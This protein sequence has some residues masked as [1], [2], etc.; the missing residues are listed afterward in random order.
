MEILIHANGLDLTDDL[1]E[2]VKEK[3]GHI[4][5]YAPRAVRV[6]VHFDRVSAHAS[7]R[8]F[9][10]HILCELPGRDVSARVSAQN[11][12]AALDSVVRKIER[13]IRRRKTHWLARRHRGGTLPE[14]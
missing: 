1:R 5:L 10:V 3:I 8:Q 4:E 6:R 7:S 13:Q 2:K 12:M 14:T 9:E 11:S